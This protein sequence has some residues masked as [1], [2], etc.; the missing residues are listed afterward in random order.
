MLGGI[1]A[2]GR[3]RG[4]DESVKDHDVIRPCR[5]LSAA[6]TR[7]GFPSSYLR[8]R[9]FFVVL[10]SF[11][12]QGRVHGLFVPGAVGTMCCC[13]VL[14]CVF[15]TAHAAALLDALGRIGRRAP[16]SRVLLATSIHCTCDS[17]NVLDLSPEYNSF[18]SVPMSSTPFRCL[19]LRLL[20]LL[21][22]SAHVLWGPCSVNVCK[23]AVES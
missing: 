10:C 17:N 23:R 6:S 5:G 11:S 2:A 3:G 21:P 22:L 14:W 20:P 7:I 9:F 18:I 4:I 8:S 16:S 19:P 1:V 13:M 15:W 12:C